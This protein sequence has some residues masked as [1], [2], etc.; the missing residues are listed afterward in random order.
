MNSDL[1]NKLKQKFEKLQIRLENQ[2][3]TDKIIKEGASEKD[4][5]HIKNIVKSFISNIESIDEEEIDTLN[6]ELTD[7][8]YNTE[9]TT[10]ISIYH[11][12]IIDTINYLKKCISEIVE[13]KVNGR[14][15]IKHKNL[16][17]KEEFS[18]RYDKLISLLNTNDK[19]S[20]LI[21]YTKKENVPFKLFKNNSSVVILPSTEINYL[22]TSKENLQEIAFD[23]KK[24]NLAAYTP[25]I[26]EKLFDNTIFDE[27]KNLKSELTENSENTKSNELRLNE[28]ENDKDKLYGEIKQLQD[29][30][31]ENEEVYET[32]KQVYEN[33]SSL[34]SDYL[35]AKETVLNDIKIQ[36]SYTY[37]EEQIDFYSKRYAKYLWTAIVLSLL[38]LAGIFKVDSTFATEAKAEVINKIEV[39]KDKSINKDIDIST[40]LTKIDFIKYGFM[41]LLI[42]LAIWVI[43]IVMKIAL[44]SYHLSIDAKE[45]VIMIKTY[46]SLMKE[47][48]TLT[49]NDKRIMIESIFRSTNHGIVKDE[50]SVTVTDIISS[51]KK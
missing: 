4:I 26:I 16:I 42:S 33:V 8:L 39:S 5:Q 18:K 21:L 30:L 38:L 9:S 23:K 29:K 13:D 48:N 6:K 50:S 43:R 31:N 47:G 49:E 25:S 1:R 36:D 24:S 45:R 20:N 37:W 22:S 51:F 40:S 28:L 3:V 19:K 2:S 17:S 14:I 44:S 27:I 12:Q 34:E 10:N 32:I 41:I 46:L 11:V 15:K 35:N 7:F